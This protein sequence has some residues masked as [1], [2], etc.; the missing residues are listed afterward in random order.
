MDQTIDFFSFGM[1]RV[2]SQIFVSRKTTFLCFFYNIIMFPHLFESKKTRTEILRRSV[3][4][5]ARELRS[6]TISSIFDDVGTKA[7]PA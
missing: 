1:A 7:T 6:E 3:Q 5:S 4:S 2:A